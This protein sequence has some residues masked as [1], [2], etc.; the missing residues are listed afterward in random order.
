M[1]YCK[2]IT[3]SSLLAWYKYTQEF[4]LVLAKVTQTVL[5]NIDIGVNFMRDVQT[6]KYCNVP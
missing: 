6:D 2:L 5:T 1:K 3:Y 4:V